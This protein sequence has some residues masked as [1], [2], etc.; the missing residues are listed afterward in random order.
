MNTS[1]KKW[2][3]IQDGRFAINLNATHMGTKVHLN[4]E[5]Q[6][7]LRLRNSMN[8]WDFHDSFCTGHDGKGYICEGGKH[9]INYI[10]I[11]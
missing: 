9:M 5:G 2:K 11:I 6:D 10:L 7:C 1:T 4:D 8:K 3:W